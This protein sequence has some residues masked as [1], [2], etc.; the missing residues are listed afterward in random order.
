MGGGDGRERAGRGVLDLGEIAARY[1]GES[2]RLW[3]R[4]LA[5]LWAASAGAGGLGGALR[6]AAAYAMSEGPIALRRQV[7]LQLEACAAVLGPLGRVGGPGRPAPSDE[8]GEEADGDGA[9]G[10]ASGPAE[11][12]LKPAPGSPAEAELLV[13]NRTAAPAE[14]SFEV[15]EFVPEVGAAF[16]APV[17]L[18]PAR[19]TL[20]PGGRQVVRCA[21]GPAPFPPGR[22][23]ARVVV[24]GS[25][26]E[27]T[28]VVQGPAAALATGA[29]R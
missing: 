15:G 23:R 6:G 1:A 19:F 8:R 29:G 17:S 18:A 24:V 22:S 16:G 11:V 20:P 2:S 12:L 14:V 28:V 25:P 27:F 26:G 21:V 9:E 7:R 10:G 13:A 3:R 4:Y 5:D